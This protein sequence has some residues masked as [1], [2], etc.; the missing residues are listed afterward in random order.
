MMSMK[1]SWIKH[2]ALQGSQVKDFS[3]AMMRVQ[4]V[5]SKRVPVLILP[6]IQQHRIPSPIPPLR[7]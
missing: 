7:Q 6:E 2:Q 4:K 1:Y 5:T 3:E